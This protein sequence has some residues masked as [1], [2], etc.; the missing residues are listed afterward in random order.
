MMFSRCRWWRV[1]ILIKKHEKRRRATLSLR[2]RRWD[3]FRPPPRGFLG[4]ETVG[5]VQSISHGVFSLV[6]SCIRADHML[7]TAGLKLAYLRARHRWISLLRPETIAN[8][9]VG[10]HAVARGTGSWNCRLLARP[11][12]GVHGSLL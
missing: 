4:L 5:E 7:W 6:A 8:L 2:L 10:R 3:L 12:I 9:R 11:P 1:I